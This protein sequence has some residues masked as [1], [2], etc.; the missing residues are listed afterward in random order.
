MSK[1]SKVRRKRVSGDSFSAVWAELEAELAAHRS[2]L[3]LSFGLEYSGIVDWAADLTPRCGHPKARQY[4]EV[5][6]GYG[7]TAAMAIARALAAMREELN[8]LTG[9]NTK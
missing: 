3:D 2:D 5:W 7:T 8:N 1:Q 9:E 6:Y 4:G